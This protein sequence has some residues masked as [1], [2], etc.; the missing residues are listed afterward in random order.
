MRARSAVI[1]ALLCGFAAARAQA[2]EQYYLPQVVDGRFERGSYR[3]TFVFFNNTD[4]NVTV[5]LKL[6]GDAGAPLVVGID[7]LGRASEFNIFLAAGATEILQTDGTGAIVTG[8]ASVTTSAKIGVSA[9]FSNF[10]A[11]GRYLT[12]AGV[13]GAEP[14]TDFVLPVDTTGLFNTGLALFNPGTSQAVITAELRDSGGQTVASANVDLAAGGHVARFVAGSGQLFP[15]VA[16]FQG[17][18]R[19]QSSAPVSALVLRQNELPLSY[20]SL[21]VVPA[22]ASTLTRNL[23]QVATGSFDG[24]V[25]KTSFLL[26]NLSPG[27]A[28]AVLAL[29]RNDGTPLSVTVPGKGTASTFNISLP[30][31]GAA[32]LQTDG[33][34][35][36]EAGA[37]TVTSTAPLGAS[38]I[39]TVF[40]PQGAFQTEAGVGD[41]PALSTLT[42]PVDMTGALQTGFAFFNPGAAAATV[43]LRLLD[44]NGVPTGARSVFTLDPKKHTAKFVA[45]LFDTTPN[46]TG[47]V[48]VSSTAPV[49]ALTLRQNQT[50]LS[51][52]TLPSAAGISAGSAAA[53]LLLSK[54][55]SGLTFTASSTFDETL[56]AGFR[57]TGQTGGQG[58]LHEI[59]A[60]RADGAVYSGEAIPETGRYVIAVPAGAY[61]LKGCF[62]PEGSGASGSLMMTYTEAALFQVSADTEHNIT[63]PAVPLHSVSGA[64]TGFSSLPS[65]SGSKIVFTS[66]DSTAQG[67]FDVGA[68]GSYRGLLPDVNYVAGLSVTGIAFPPVQHEDLAVYS[69]GTTTVNGGPVTVS[70]PSPATAKVSG[71]VRAAW[72]GQFAFGIT[73]NATDRAAPPP[74]ICIL[75][76]A[77]SAATA[78]PAGQYQ[79]ILARDRNYGMRAAVPL[80]KGSLRLGTVG[81]P[82]SG[83]ALNLGAD[84]P[85][86]FNLPPLPAQVALAGRVTD[87]L[88]RGVEGVTV[89]AHTETL[90]D[91]PNAS[92]SAS[93]VTDA[94]G[95]YTLTVLSGS[96]YQLTFLPPLQ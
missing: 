64:I 88:G 15:S 30:G 72:L 92:Y 55:E 90:S 45:E 28:N 23:A 67:S 12:E 11:D 89:A 20:T 4:A 83:A 65:G 6:T 52:T 70:F 51:Y 17:T 48:S 86:D 61:R 53:P 42:F 54:T 33:S 57:L 41:S 1:V 16:A 85:Y 18:L 24:G 7:S 14:Q 93:T 58:Q 78:D 39:F 71:T 26:F 47:T 43:T 19:V 56:G 79:I 40:D 27:A 66:G 95:K 63:L 49:A 3:T 25:F 59:V 77:D 34:G 60:V 22:G 80:L 75:P 74:D 31:R 73:V 37:A 46:F 62:Q 69:L 2:E 13:G 5:L 32:F 44:A 29:T 84:A 36:L 8:A 50:P 10:D 38:A 96:H 82:V 35:T 21:P 81:Y 9:I 87:R 91:T 76:P 94:E 68:D